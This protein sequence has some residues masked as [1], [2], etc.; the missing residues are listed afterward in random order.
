M[1]DRNDIP[2][3]LPGLLSLDSWF[4][5]PDAGQQ[6]LN[7]DCSYRQEIAWSPHGDSL[8]QLTGRLTLI[9]DYRKVLGYEEG[10]LETRIE[11][12][13]TFKRFTFGAAVDF[14]SVTHDDTALGRRGLYA[15]RSPP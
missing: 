4:G 3:Y 6:V 11:A 2:S 8:H 9:P 5:S 1:Q 15:L 13:R 12:Q 14:L 10:S 7:A